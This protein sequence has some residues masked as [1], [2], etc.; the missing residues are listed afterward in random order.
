VEIRRRKP[1]E[2]L[3]KEVVD[4]SG[5]ARKIRILLTSTSFGSLETLL[6]G[7]LVQRAYG[8]LRGDA[9]PVFQRCDAL[10]TLGDFRRAKKVLGAEVKE[11]GSEPDFSRF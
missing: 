10:L 7:R 6:S 4:P 3:L 2:E 1:A 5:P 9:S 11:R 8:E